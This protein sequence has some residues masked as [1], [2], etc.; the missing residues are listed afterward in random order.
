MDDAQLQAQ[1]DDDSNDAPGDLQVTDTATDTTKGTR[2]EEEPQE[3]EMEPV[4]QMMGVDQAI[5]KSIERCSKYSIGDL[6]HN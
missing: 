3:V 2:I 5:L 1:M 4:L 6:S